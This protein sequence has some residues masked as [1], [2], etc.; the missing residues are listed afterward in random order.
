MSET[1]EEVNI[2]PI[3]GVYANYCN[4]GFNAFEFLLDFGQSYENEKPH[5]NARI[6]TSPVHA[7]EILRVLSLSIEEYES[8]Y[9]PIVDH[10]WLSAFKIGAVSCW[11]Q[12][13]PH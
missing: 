2:K 3:E 4:I 11:I 10:D 1:D 13:P 8:K 9:S 5:T 7:K 12:F 6:I